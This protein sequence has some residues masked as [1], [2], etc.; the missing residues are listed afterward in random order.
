MIGI[1][2]TV[3]RVIYQAVYEKA[4]EDGYDVWK[5]CELL[6]IPYSEKGAGESVMLDNDAEGLLMEEGESLY[7]SYMLVKEKKLY[8]IVD[9]DWNRVE[10]SLRCD[11]QEIM[12]D[13]DFFYEENGILFVEYDYNTSSYCSSL[14]ML[15]KEGIVTELGEDVYHAL[16]LPDGSVMYLA[17]YDYERLEGDL[18]LWKKG[19]SSLVEEDV[20]FLEY[21]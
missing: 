15:Q 10:G 9:Y 17:D 20:S 16:V 1:V 4:L 13:V 5:V 21:R 14:G 12:D 19:E 18:Y 11:G 2:D 3:N 6:K 7:S 8:Y